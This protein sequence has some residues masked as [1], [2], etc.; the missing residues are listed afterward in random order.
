[1]TDSDTSA[2]DLD[3]ITLE[4]MFDMTLPEGEALH[5]LTRTVLAKP[6][7]PTLIS[8]PAAGER[9]RH[10]RTGREVTVLNA[11]DPRANGFVHVR[12]KRR[13][14]IRTRRFLAEYVR[15]CCIPEDAD[16]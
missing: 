2:E 9:W 3:D 14:S 7:H 5:E 8:H 12:G 1:M 4:D 15:C 13:S 11:D 6:P 10:R 16:A